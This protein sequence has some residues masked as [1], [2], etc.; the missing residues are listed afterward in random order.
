MRRWFQGERVG[1]WF[2]AAGGHIREPTYDRLPE[3]RAV[4]ASCPGGGVLWA[5]QGTSSLE[6]TYRFGE[7]EWIIAVIEESGRSQVASEMPVPAAVQVA[8]RVE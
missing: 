6:A 4:E 7:A 5:E 2:V 8:N 3:L 1:G